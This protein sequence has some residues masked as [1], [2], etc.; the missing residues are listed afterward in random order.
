[1][2]AG[3]AATYPVTYYDIRN[4]PGA[5]DF[6]YREKFVTDEDIYIRR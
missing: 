2:G 4:P 6:L 3:E 1:M 5:E